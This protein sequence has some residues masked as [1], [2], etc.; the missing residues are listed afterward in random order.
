MVDKCVKEKELVS[1]RK[2]MSAKKEVAEFKQAIGFK[3]SFKASPK[4]STMLEHKS[5][6]RRRYEW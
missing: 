1:P 3:E 5:S 6:S 2:N 4:H